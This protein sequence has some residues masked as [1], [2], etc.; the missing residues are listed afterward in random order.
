[1]Y[2]LGQFGALRSHSRSS[3]M[4]PFDRAHA[5]SYSTLIETVRLS[6]TVFEIQP[7]IY[8][9]SP[10]LT[11]PTCIWRPRRGLPRSNVAEIF[12][13][14]ILVL[15]LSCGVVCLILSLAVLVELRLVTDRRT[16]GRTDG[17]TQGHGQY[18]GCIASRG[19]NVI[20]HIVC[21]FV[22]SLQRLDLA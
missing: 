21:R 22:W 14:R 17:Q 20:A 8:R 12:G 18:R 9:K 6:C 15:G 7:V 2:T 4:S 11:H 5:T 1:M 13:V 3:A 19:K 16:D 10:I